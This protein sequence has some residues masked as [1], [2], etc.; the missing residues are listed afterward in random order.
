MNACAVAVLAALSVFEY[1]A[2]QAEHD[3]LKARFIAAVRE[4]DFIAMRDAAAK[5]CEL[6]PD[7]PVWAYNLACSLSRLE[8]KDEA[9]DALER[10]VRLGFRD[11]T[12]IA[13]D[14]D[15]RFLAKDDRFG[16]ILEDADRL[17]TK[18][19][20][21]GP[22][23]AVPATGVMGMPLVLGAHNLSWN[24]DA[25]CF[26]AK[27][28]L[29]PGAGGGNEGDLY[30]NRDGGHS[31][32][33]VAAFPGL[34]HTVLDAEAR[35]HHIDLDIP[36]MEFPYPVFGNCSRAIVNG[37]LWRSLPRAIMTTEARRMALMHRFYRSNQVWAFP[38][39]GDCPPVGTNGDVFA[40]AAPYW[41]ATEGKS[42]SD[43]PWLRA[44][45]EVSRS[46]KPAVKEEAVRRGM[47]APLIQCILRKTLPGV[48]TEDDYLTAKA[49]PT[50]MPTAGP[51]LARV[52][53]LAASFEPGGLPPLATLRGVAGAASPGATTG[54]LS[55]LTYVTPCAAALVL[56]LPER[57]RTF[58][59]A[60][61]GPDGAEFTFAA[62][63][64]PEGAAK[65]SRIT[66]DAVK[67]E[68]DRDALLPAGR[69]DLAVFARNPGGPWGAPSFVSFAAFSPEAPYRDPALFPEPAAAPAKK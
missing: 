59:V 56:R 49:H 30:F 20:L 37:V 58:A 9:L 15:L 6:L 8:R 66:P 40:S 19:T 43:C 3:A 57:R 18:P 12:A 41:I 51:D 29:S 46:L 48:T 21:T 27:L 34:T 5:G 38:V 13:S 69:I 7:D 54:G 62:V 63:H 42:W 67:V 16:E 61:A 17:L 14:A 64:G 32:L 65:I 10:A 31:L 52:K 47:L 22:L 68:I 23:S 35:T 50:A 25:G 39:V 36:N 1:P 60:A 53:A 2:R 55:E 28:S 24:L 33:D 11:H 4:R 26:E 44:A 45:L